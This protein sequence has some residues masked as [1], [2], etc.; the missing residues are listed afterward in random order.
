MKKSEEFLA[1]ARQLAE[2]SAVPPGVESLLWEAQNDFGVNQQKVDELLQASNWAIPLRPKVVL[3]AQINQRS[4][5]T[6]R[7]YPALI[8]DPAIRAGQTEVDNEDALEFDRM[9]LARCAASETWGGAPSRPLNELLWFRDALSLRPELHEEQKG[10][11]EALFFG[12]KAR[13]QELIDELAGSLEVTYTTG[14]LPK[15]KGRRLV[16]W[17]LSDDRHEARK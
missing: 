11:V 3:Y 6:V 12:L 17:K 9:F 14:M 4:N 5:L 16:G 1:Q 15:L 7:W 8:V 2:R 13:Y 10:L